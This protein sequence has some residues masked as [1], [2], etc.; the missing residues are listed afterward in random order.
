[1]GSMESGPAKIGDLLSTILAKYGY[2]NRTAQEELER[3]WRQAAS[4]R[5]QKHT[6]IGSVR[7]GVLEVFVD[8]AVLLQQLESYHKEELLAKLREVVRHSSVESLRFRRL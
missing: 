2:A 1:M 5:I 8:N 6:R 7:R 3:A 4:D